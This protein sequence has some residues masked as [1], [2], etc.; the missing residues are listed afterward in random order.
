MEAAGEAANFFASVRT[1][2]SRLRPNHSLFRGMVNQRLSTYE[3]KL[4]Y[5]NEDIKRTNIREFTGGSGS[6]GKLLECIQNKPVLIDYRSLI[7]MDILVL[8]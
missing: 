5:A 1:G 4:G 6:C 8:N 2:E 3:L 7:C